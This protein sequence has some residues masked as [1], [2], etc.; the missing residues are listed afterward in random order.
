MDKQQ[1]IEEQRKY[2]ARIRQGERHLIPE[3]WEMLR[4]LTARFINRYLMCRKSERLYDEADLWQESYIALVNAL[5][6]WQPEKG[7]FSMVYAWSYSNPQFILIPVF[8]FAAA[9][10]RDS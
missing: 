8:F 7:S 10:I 4:P 1:L 3:L 9:G 2:I 6:Y 5:D